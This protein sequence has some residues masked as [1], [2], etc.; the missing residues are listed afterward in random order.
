MAYILQLI[1]LYA[2]PVLIAAAFITC[3][4]RYILA[5]RGNQKAPGSYTRFQLQAR[6]VWLIVT[7]VPFLVLL[8]L[9]VG[10]ILILAGAISLM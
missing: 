9:L 8:L 1:A 6:L 3:L 2:V 10:L 4:V 5:L 7:A